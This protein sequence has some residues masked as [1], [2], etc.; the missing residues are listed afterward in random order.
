MLSF[1]DRSGAVRAALL[2]GVAGLALVGVPVR[3]ETLQEALALAYQNNPTLQ[4]A[5]AQLRAVDENVPIAL[6]GWRPTLTVNG[7]VQR[8]RNESV[9]TSAVT[10]GQLVAGGTTLRTSELGTVTLRQPLFRGLR[11]TA[12]TA[13][14]KS[15][16]MAQRARLEQSEAQV[17]FETATSYL[18]VLRDQAVLNLQESNVQ[19]LNRQLE[20]TRDRFRVG[21]ITRT[22]VAQAE[23]RVAGA[24]ASRIQAEGQLQKSRATYENNVGKPPEALVQPETTPPLPPTV[25]ES[26]DRAIRNNPNYLAADFTAQAAQNAVDVS[27]G[28][29]L[30]SVDAEVLYNKGYD[31]LADKSK[32][33]VATARAVVTV[34]L[35][36]QGAEYARLRQSKHTA[37]QR[38]LEADQARQDAREL[39][40]A[41]WENYTSATASI[42]SFNSQISAAQIA[43]EGVQREAEVGSRTVLDVLDAE[44]ELLNA[45]VNLVRAQRDQLVAAYQLMSS[46]GDLDAETL[47]LPVNI[48][49]PTGHYEDVKNKAFGS[50]I[51]AERDRDLAGTPTN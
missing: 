4:A 45:R 9:I 47:G 43:L 19:V 23:A 39:A 25:E 16:V 40:A 10:S 51:D 29:L 21:E 31:T 11:T 48:Y 1:R 50:S 13:Q 2:A 44:Q 15:L 8:Q 22:D 30:P 37:G 26:V 14:A 6:S 32:N 36:Q 20:A 3:A 35:Y 17:L 18:D 41:S 7:N 5:R 27:R 42:Q 46:V 24:I 28:D 34:P 12:G 49:D 38:R 33:N